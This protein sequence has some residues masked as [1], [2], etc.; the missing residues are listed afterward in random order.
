MRE[1]TD[2]DHEHNLSIKTDGKNGHFLTTNSHVVVRKWDGQHIL[3]N[4]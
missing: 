2:T 1:K 3:I 4:K